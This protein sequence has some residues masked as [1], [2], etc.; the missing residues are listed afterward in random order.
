MSRI[1]SS[2][3]RPEI[4]VRRTLHAMGFRFRLH[5]KDLPGRPDL[6]LPRYRL[7]LFVHGCFWHQHA[8]CKLASKPKTRRDYW[9]PKLAGNISRDEQSAKALRSLGWRVE[10]IWECETRDTGRLDARLTEIM[11]SV[12]ELGCA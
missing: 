1:R 4:A 6:V 9:D 12:A 5:R 2:D 8:A 3:T 7:V 10:V 11:N